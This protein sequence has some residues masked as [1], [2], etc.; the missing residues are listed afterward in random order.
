[1]AEWFVVWLVSHVTHVRARQSVVKMFQ[2]FTFFLSFDVF[3]WSL[4][5]IC[6]VLHCFEATCVVS[7]CWRLLMIVVASFTLLL[8][9]LREVMMWGPTI[10]CYVWNLRLPLTKIV[11]PSNAALC[12]NIRPATYVWVDFLN[13]PF[14]PTDMFFVLRTPL[15]PFTFLSF[16]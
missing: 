2:L 4:K 1:M 7:C 8:H 14:S 13:L 11:Q 5:L 15:I 9:W 3:V 12:M 16:E 10:M 6:I